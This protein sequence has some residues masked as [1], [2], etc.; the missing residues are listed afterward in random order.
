MLI[1]SGVD[2]LMAAN[3]AEMSELY[4]NQ[5]VSES[6]I[7]SFSHDSRNLANQQLEK[8]HV[9]NWKKVKSWSSFGAGLKWAMHKLNMQESV[10]GTPWT[11]VGMSDG[12]SPIRSSGIEYEVMWNTICI[13]WIKLWF[14]G[15]PEGFFRVSRGA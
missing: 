6:G 3:T 4:A 9:T 15:F 13:L 2:V 10:S 11:A 7:H 12:A 14:R 1:R 8:V 5:R